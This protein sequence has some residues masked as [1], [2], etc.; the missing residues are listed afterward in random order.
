M[1]QVP[2][3]EQIRYVP[4][5]IGYHS[6]QSPEHVLSMLT[7]ILEMCLDGTGFSVSGVHATNVVSYLGSFS[8]VTPHPPFT[9]SLCP[10]PRCD[11]CKAQQLAD[12]V[13]GLLDINVCLRV[14]QSCLVAAV[15][16]TSI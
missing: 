4:F 3:A 11:G 16:R 15:S 5:D 2:D 10:L 8:H 13:R 6:K 9:A 12:V 1:L 7:P 14:Q